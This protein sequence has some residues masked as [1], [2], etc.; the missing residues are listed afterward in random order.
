[1]PRSAADVRRVI[2]A[3]DVRGLVGTE[4][5]EAFVFDVGAAFAGLMRAEGAGS[6]VIG[7][8]MRESSPVLSTEFADS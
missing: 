6:V 5:D 8:D 1:M 7:H 4:L 2:K 3:Y